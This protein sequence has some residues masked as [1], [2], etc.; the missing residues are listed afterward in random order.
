MNTFQQLK[1]VDLSMRTISAGHILLRASFHSR[2]TPLV[3]CKPPNNT[4]FM[5]ATT[6]PNQ[7]QI[8]QSANKPNVKEAS[9]VDT[10]PPCAPI[11]PRRVLSPML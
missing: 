7:P 2:Q 9:M 3:A 4:C 10:V 8:T 11:L 5:E 6:L 1:V